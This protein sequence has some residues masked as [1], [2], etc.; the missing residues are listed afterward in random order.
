MKTGKEV[1]EI[2]AEIAS[3][4]TG[5]PV[6][7]SIKAL[8]F[9]LNLTK[10]K[11]GALY[12]LLKYRSDIIREKI[13]KEDDSLRNDWHEENIG[14]TVSDRMIK[15]T[16]DTLKNEM[17][18]KK[19]KH[20]AY[21]CGNVHLT[22]N[23]RISISTAIEILNKIETLSYRQFCVIKYINEK[24]ETKTLKNLQKPVLS[25]TRDELLDHFSKMPEDKKSDFFSTCRE[26][27]VL[28]PQGYT[29]GGT[30]ANWLET[31]GS[32]RALTD[33]TTNPIIERIPLEI[34]TPTDVAKEIYTLAELTKIPEEDMQETFQY[35]E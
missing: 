13:G 18:E 30:A 10:N 27:V 26:I 33:G 34:G 22:S 11:E 12:N 14:T 1:V 8:A 16:F 35:W 15:K 6:G 20:I 24:R 31:F 7:V 28:N 4:I 5:L 25:S 32:G 9:A 29:S 21:F 19:Q 3:I 23:S 17:D 2:S